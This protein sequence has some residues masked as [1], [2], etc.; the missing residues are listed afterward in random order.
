VITGTSERKQEPSL[1]VL[2]LMGDA[3]QLHDQPLHYAELAGILAGEGRVDLR[4]TR[5][6]SVLSPA[7]LEEVDVVVNWTTFLD[8]PDEQLQ[9]LLGAVRHG[10]GFVA[11][12][13]GSATFW[14]SA[15]YLLMLGSRFINHEPIKRFWVHIEQPSHPIVAGISDFETEDELF[16]IGGDTG[17]FPAFTKAFSERGW[18][19]DVVRMGAGPLPPDVT[20]LASAENRPL[21][22]TRMFGKGRVHYNALGH[23]ERTLRNSN[24]RRLVVQGVKWTAAN[25]RAE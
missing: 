2:L 24:Y 23:D 7:Q 12:H 22:Y 15:E 20:V 21:L 19:D 13:G 18:A 4:I 17:T 9:A 16:E 11:L 1:R 6:L 5:D 10:T 8:V 3:H 14:N 25:H